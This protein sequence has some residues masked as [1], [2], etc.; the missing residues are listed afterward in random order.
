MYI[1]CSI[2]DLNSFFLVKTLKYDTKKFS[3]IIALQAIKF[4]SI[5]LY[6]WQPELK[7]IKEFV[8]APQKEDLRYL[9]EFIKK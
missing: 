6:F 2:S 1:W 3:S 7:S 4:V 8:F 5:Y 9:R